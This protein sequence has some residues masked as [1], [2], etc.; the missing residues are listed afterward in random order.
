MSLHMSDK[1]KLRARIEAI[2]K[3]KNET[4]QRVSTPQ[5]IHCVCSILKV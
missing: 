5:I 1:E 3:K 4:K 2:D